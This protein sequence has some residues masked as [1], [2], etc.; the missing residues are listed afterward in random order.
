MA[1]LKEIDEFVG[2][3]EDLRAKIRGALRI[4]SMVI[5]NDPASTAAQNVFALACLG[6]PAQYEVTALNGIMGEYNLL[7]IAAIQGAT[8]A[9]IQAAVNKVV[10]QLLGVA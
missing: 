8:D 10:D 4:K 1:T 7:T 9:N 5:V 3:A 2:S 6:N